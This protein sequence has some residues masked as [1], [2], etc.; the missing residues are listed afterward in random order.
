MVQATNSDFRLLKTVEF[1][2]AC[3]TDSYPPTFHVH[4]ND[5]FPMKLSLALAFF[6]FSHFTAAQYFSEGWKPGQAVTKSSAGFTF[7]TASA[8]E[9]TPTSEGKAP[10]DFSSLLEAGPLK[11]LF[12]RAGVNISERLEAA[13]QSVRI[14]DERIPLITDDNYNELIVN[15]KFETPE[16]EKKRAWFLVMY[17]KF[18]HD[19]TRVLVLC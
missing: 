7:Q 15:E 18:C 16:E 5:C 6:A 3:W 13:R 14:W 17:V 2:R 12:Q 4:L 1:T 11:S 8:P 9:S 19:S 10:F